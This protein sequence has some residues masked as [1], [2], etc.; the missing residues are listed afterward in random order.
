MIIPILWMKTLIHMELYGVLKAAG[1]VHGRAGFE[2]RESDSAFV[3]LATVQ[4]GVENRSLSTVPPS[5][6]WA[7]PSCRWKSWELGV[8]TPLQPEFYT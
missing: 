1:L 2:S 4:V 7:E 8:R 6:C 5:F 3:P